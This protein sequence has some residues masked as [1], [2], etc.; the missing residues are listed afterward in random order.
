MS[1]QSDFSHIFLDFRPQNPCFFGCI[2]H[3]FF[4]HVPKVPDLKKT[5]FAS[6]GAIKSRVRALKQTSKCIKK[7]IKIE[8][9]KKRRQKLVEKSMLGL[10]LA[11]KTSPKSLQNPSKTMLRTKTKKRSKKV[12]NKTP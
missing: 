6:T 3:A 7:T 10:I 2:L 9:T 11:S 5:R 8:G 1:F 4:E 12:A